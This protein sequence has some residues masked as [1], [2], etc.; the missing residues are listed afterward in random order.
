METNLSL[1]TVNYEKPLLVFN[2]LVSFYKTNKHLSG[3]D[4]I[5]FDNSSSEESAEFFSE[6]NIP[7]VSGKDYDIHWW[8][9]EGKVDGRQTCHGNAIREAI[10]LCK[11]KYLLLIDTD[12]DFKQDI[13]RGFT[14]HV[15]NNSVFSGLLERDRVPSRPQSFVEQYPNAT[16]SEYDSR[17]RTIYPRI[18]PHY[19]FIDVE[20]WRENKIYFN[21]DAI[22]PE[23]GCD[24]NIEEDIKGL[25]QKM[26]PIVFDVGSYP[27]WQAGNQKLNCTVLQQL[28]SGETVTNTNNPYINH[29]D[30]ES[31]LNKSNSI[32]PVLR[33][34]YEGQTKTIFSEINKN[35]FYRKVT[36]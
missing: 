4:L 9:D 5:L 7:F 3:V 28:P 22:W 19:M 15:V 36:K 27:L 8:S 33:E 21:G 17:P 1:A 14:A 6:N 12:I 13:G 32:Y 2:A 29:Y 11:T 16:A 23:G 35:N 26:S 30:S 34:K 10:N 25:F 31:R 18:C 20:Q 24:P